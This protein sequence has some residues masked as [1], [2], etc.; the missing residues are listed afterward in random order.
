MNLKELSELTKTV[1]GVGL[2]PQDV[3]IEWSFEQLEKLT[4]DQVLKLQGTIRDEINY[5][6]KINGRIRKFKKAQK[7]V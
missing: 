5:L 2:K 3:I 6:E 7:I 1:F 4:D